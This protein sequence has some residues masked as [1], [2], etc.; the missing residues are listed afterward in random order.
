MLEPGA[1]RRSIDNP[2]KALPHFAEMFWVQEFLACCSVSVPEMERVWGEKKGQPASQA[3]E[4]LQ[5][6]PGQF[7][8]RE[9]QCAERWKQI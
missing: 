5:E 1:V 8:H 9:T 7:A 6:I 2:A 3:K 4:S